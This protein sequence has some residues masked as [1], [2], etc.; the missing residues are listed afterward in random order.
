MFSYIY[1]YNSNPFCP[2]STISNQHFPTFSQ[3]IQSLIISNAIFCQ[4]QY[5]NISYPYL[6]TF[7]S[8]S[9]ETNSSSQNQQ[10]RGQKR[11]SRQC[12]SNYVSFL[13]FRESKTKI[14]RRTKPDISNSI[15]WWETSTKNQN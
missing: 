7:Y 2:I 5:S 12:K 6:T 10:K 3:Y 8:T 11:K 9:F 15:W 14:T 13:I 4:S 1:I